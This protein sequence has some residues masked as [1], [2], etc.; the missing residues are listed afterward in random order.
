LLP[1]KHDKITELSY[2]LKESLKKH[3]SPGD[4]EMISSFISFE[5]NEK[6]SSFLF[7]KEQSKIFYNPE[8]L[9]VDESG[10]DYKSIFEIDLQ[11][12]LQ[13]FEDFIECGNQ[14]N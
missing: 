10:W 7:S 1:L 6:V 2:F 12:A 9:N 5:E 13:D 14:L 3:F 11:N 4:L 8:I